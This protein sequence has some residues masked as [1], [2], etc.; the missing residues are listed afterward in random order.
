V[1]IIRFADRR[2]F[3]SIANEAL[4][5][6]RLSFRARGLLAW[7]LSK[8]DGWTVNSESIVDS[9]AEGRDA[10]RTALNELEKVGYLLRENVRNDKGQWISVSTIYE[11]PGPG[12]P[13]S[14][15]RCLDSRPSGPRPSGNQAVITKDSEVKTDKQNTLR[16]KG[17]DD[18]W[19]GYPRKIG[20]PRAK[21]AWKRIKP[22][23]RLAVM[24]GL[25]VWAQYWSVMMTE[26]RFI[27]HAATWLND[28]R[29]EDLPDLKD[30]TDGPR[31]DE[32]RRIWL[33]PGVG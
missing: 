24:L 13:S 5:D 22:D 19:S 15:N 31:W 28:K 20:K 11:S 14:D 32:K 12:N 16:E 30:R 21:T 18:F 33:A 29:W 7:L 27:P 17:F 23:D 2:R 9:G 1:S 4:E 26:V 25:S 6:A 3:T 10:I 8:P